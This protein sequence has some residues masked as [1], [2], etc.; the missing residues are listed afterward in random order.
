MRGKLA[1]PRPA[2]YIQLR[3]DDTALEGVLQSV[4]RILRC[5][6]IVEEELREVV[7]STNFG[8]RSYTCHRFSHTALHQRSEVC[9]PVKDEDESTEGMKV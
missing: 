3:Y 6:R 7:G 5:C 8:L 2:V 4:G 9:K 1:V